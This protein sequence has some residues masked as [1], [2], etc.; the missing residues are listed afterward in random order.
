MNPKSINTAA[1]LIC[2]GMDDK[3]GGDDFQGNK[4]PGTFRAS[5]GDSDADKK[6]LA[7]YD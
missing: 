5:A 7:M 6:K 1:Y 4:E 2:A 3:D